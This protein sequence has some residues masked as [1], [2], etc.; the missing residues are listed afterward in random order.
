MSNRKTKNFFENLKKML[1]KFLIL[2][3]LTAVIQGPI[4]KVPQN[5]KIFFFIKVLQNTLGEIYKKLRM[6]FFHL[7]QK[8]TKT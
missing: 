2:S 1:R 6:Y 4:E 5:G 7:G 3:L 8:M